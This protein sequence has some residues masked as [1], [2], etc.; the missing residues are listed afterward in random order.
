MQ[1][2]LKSDEGQ[3][4]LSK[5]VSESL[6]SQWFQTAAQTTN[7]SVYKNLYTQQQQKSQQQL[8]TLF[9]KYLQENQNNNQLASQKL[10][11]NDLDPVGGNIQAYEQKELN[12]WAKTQFS[13]FLFANNYLTFKDNNQQLVAL[14]T[15]TT[16]NELLTALKSDA[17]VFAT[18]QTNLFDV[19]YAKFVN[20]L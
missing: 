2:A 8:R 14:P 12:S 3:K 7:S 4:Q 6:I 20:Y 17:F 5:Y 13:T 19:E 15:N 18:N 10:Q 1:E 9:S 16:L 11:N